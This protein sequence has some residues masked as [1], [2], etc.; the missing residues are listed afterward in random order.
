MPMSVTIVDQNNNPL[1]TDT[2]ITTGGLTSRPSSVKSRPAN[3]TQYAL[4]DLVA[5]NATAGNV[6]PFQWTVGNGRGG[7]I[8]GCTVFKTGTSVVNT[9]FRL[10]LFSAL[11]TVTNGDNATLVPVGASRIGT[12]D[13]NV[14]L[15]C[16]DGAVGDGEPTYRAY[17]P[18]D[19]DTDIVYG[20]L[21]ARAAYA[22]ASGINGS[23]EAI[24]IYLDVDGN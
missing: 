19:Q 6:S 24:T 9:L 8:F 14:D 10:H 3:T 22:P 7:R 13:I 21:E 4:Y 1:G 23:G 15:A 18:F 2:P 20:L 5:N 16:S 12:L 11:P 17:V